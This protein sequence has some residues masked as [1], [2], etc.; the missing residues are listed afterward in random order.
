MT[1]C[2]VVFILSFCALWA[3]AIF[4][5][6]DHVLSLFRYRLWRLRD[7]LQDCILD[8]RLPELPVVNDL[9]DTVESMI[10]HADRVTLSSFVAFGLA[11]GRGSDEAGEEPFDLCGLSDEQ[12]EL[13]NRIL[14]NLFDHMA[15]KTI[16][17]SPVG[18]FFLP[19]LLPLL[20]LRTKYWAKPLIEPQAEF[21][22]VRDFR[23]SVATQG[24]PTRD[25]LVAT[26]G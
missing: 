9:F 24:K 17:G 8:E 23:A 3:C 4:M 21:R 2:A 13:F 26:A 10:E 15:F 11:G 19:I 18:G 22:H 14:S 20:R 12:R 5:V 16:A 25:T 1:I 6:P 7:H